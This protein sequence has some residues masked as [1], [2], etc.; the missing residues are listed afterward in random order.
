MRIRPPPP[1]TKAELENERYEQYLAGEITA[2]EVIEHNLRFGEVPKHEMTASP[3]SL[4]TG[5]MAEVK[6]ALY[7]Q[8]IAGEITLD[9]ATER[10]KAISLAQARE[11]LSPE[12]HQV[13]SEFMRVM[14]LPAIETE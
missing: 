13:L 14:P 1:Q 10:M 5:T 8:Y 6:E 9:E 2:D 12:D 11:Y 3:S 4:P 7:E